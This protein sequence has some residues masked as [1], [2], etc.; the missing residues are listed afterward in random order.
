MPAEGVAWVPHNDILTFEEIIRICRIMAGVK[1]RNIKV[2]GGEPLVRRGATELVK[3]LKNLPGIEKVTMTSNGTLLGG[4]LDD[5]SQAGLDAVNI[6]LDSVNRAIFRR[7]TGKDGIE[8]IFAAIRRAGELGLPVKINCVPLRGVNECD[9]VNIA[10]LAKKGNLMVRFIELMP[11]GAAAVFHPIPVKD[12]ISMLEK[13][14]G[15]LMPVTDKIGNGPASYYTLSGFTGYIGFISA[16]SHRFC[17][18]CNRLR[19]SAEGFLKPCLS[20]NMELDLRALLRGGASDKKI[21]TAI[22]ELVMCKP[23][24]HSFLSG[25]HG[26]KEMF[27]IGG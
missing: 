2:T 20:G 23:E 4:Y 9:V 3:N 22:E 25:G 21:E 17:A 13:E 10:G 27:R 15:F 8:Q 19:L 6:S 24:Q 11:L 26:Q 14:Y 7:I 1:I 12:L 5:L 18:G 16:L